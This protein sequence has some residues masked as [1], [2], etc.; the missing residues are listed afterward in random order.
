MQ[1]PRGA[2]GV[3][4]TRRGKESSEECCYSFRLLLSSAAD[5]SRRPRSPGQKNSRRTAASSSALGKHPC[6][7]SGRA[8]TRITRQLVEDVDRYL[9][10]DGVIH[11]ELELGLP[12]EGCEQFV[13]VYTGD[14]DVLAMGAGVIEE[15]WCL[16]LL[17]LTA[18]LH[19]P[20]RSGSGE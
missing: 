12:G 17:V 3:P 11:K 9:V 4:L 5:S 2:I 16:F 10:V 8:L 7:P 19:L 13:S 6:S 14:V 20:R 18:R 15:S 1:N